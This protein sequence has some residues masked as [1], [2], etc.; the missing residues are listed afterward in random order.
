MLQYI[1]IVFIIGSDFYWA[2]S[3]NKISIEQKRNLSN[4]GKIYST[5]VKEKRNY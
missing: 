5:P 4:N 3:L 1:F 2:K